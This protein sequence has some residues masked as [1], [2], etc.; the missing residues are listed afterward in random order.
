MYPFVGK[1]LKFLE[2]Q[3][4]EEV[5]EVEKPLYLNEAAL[6]YPQTALSALVKETKHLFENVFEILA[7]GLGLH[8]VEALKKDFDASSLTPITKYN[9]DKSYYKR[10]KNI[11]GKIIVFAARAQ[12]QSSD[13]EYIQTIYNIKAANRY[14]VD[15]IKDVKDLQ[16]NLL[17]YTTTDNA[18]MRNEYNIF[19]LK[20]SKIIRQ[21]FKAQKFDVPPDKSINEL[22]AEHIKGRRKQLTK[23]LLRR[24]KDDLLFNGKIDRLIRDKLITTA[25][26]SSLM[27]DSALTAAI[28]KHLIKATELLYLNPNIL[29][30]KV[31][32]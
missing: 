11:Y 13:A 5:V 15:A 25:M 23:N 18:A 16:H 12:E 14:F 28:T 10:V 3:I 22:V 21:V 29:L 9:I 27:N 31:D 32:V 7:H 2:K 19:R 6:A 20:I 26:A 8:R 24:R 1:L 17:K 30:T 4:K